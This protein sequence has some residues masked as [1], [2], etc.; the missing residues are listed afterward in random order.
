[1]QAA[2]VAPKKVQQPSKIK[3]LTEKAIEE[4]EKAKPSSDP[5]YWAKSSCNHCYGRGLL[6]KVTVVIESNTVVQHAICSCVRR[7]FTKWRDAWVAE[8]L[9]AHALA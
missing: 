9:K 6:G 5:L 3:T 7:R 1:M 4:S 8:Y 2:K